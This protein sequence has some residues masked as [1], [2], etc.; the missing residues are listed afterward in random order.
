MSK[1]P[2]F[3]LGVMKNI[4]RDASSIPASNISTSW[5]VSG[6]VG[7]GRPKCCAIVP[8]TAFK[9]WHFLYFL[10]LP[11]RHSSLRAGAMEWRGAGAM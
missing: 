5:S 6:R 3:S 1:K 4:L 10:P 7:D 8:S 9:A 11:H 2:C